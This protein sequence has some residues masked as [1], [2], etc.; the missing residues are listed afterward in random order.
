[1]RAPNSAPVPETPL[2]SSSRS[3]LAEL[4]GGYAYGLALDDTINLVVFHGLTAGCAAVFGHVNAP[5]TMAVGLW[6]QGL[7]S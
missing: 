3:T 4:K 2:I 5:C 6:E 7:A 1:M